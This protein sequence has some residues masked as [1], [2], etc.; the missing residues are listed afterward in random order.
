MDITIFPYSLVRYS[1]LE[2]NLLDDWQ[3]K[4]IDTR[5]AITILKEQICDKLFLL[6]NQQTDDKA[7]QKLIQLKRAI[8][9]DKPVN[10]TIPEELT[11]DM[12]LLMTARQVKK[13][14]ELHYDAQLVSHRKHLQ[15]LAGEE[16]LQKGILLSSP[17]LLEQMSHYTNKAPVDFK[18]KEYKIE[19]SLLRYITRMCFKTSP[20]ST[21]TYTGLMILGDHKTTPFREVKS[22]LKLNNSLFGYLMAII[23]QH[24][25]LNENLLLT[26]NSTTE[27][28]HAKLN[29]FVNYHNVEAFQQ[30]P[31]TTLNELILQQRNNIRLSELITAI[32][33][34]IEDVTYDDLKE[35][36]LKLAA[37]GLLEPGIGI[38][39]ME[40]DWSHQLMTY[41]SGQPADMI[42]QLHHWQESYANETAAGRF[43]ILKEAEVLV[44][45]VCSALQL[46]A[47]LPVATLENIP[48][49]KQLQTMQ[50]A[51]HHF[52]GRQIFYEDC[53][54]PQIEILAADPVRNIISKTDELL[55]YLSP[56]DTMKAEREKMRDFFINHYAQDERVKVITFYKDY[57]Y[58]VKKHETIENSTPAFNIQLPDLSSAINITADCF[59]HKGAV[60]SQSRG[61]FVQ[62]F[63][64]N[65]CGVINAILPGMGKVNG[66]FLSLFDKEV[67]D[68]FIEYNNR[69][70]PDI[71]KAE[72]NDASS[73]N[74]NIH[75]PLLSYE[76]TIP[77]GNNIYPANQ[78]I[79]VTALDVIYKSGTLHLYAGTKEIYTY[80]LSLESFNNRSNLYKLLAHFN[81]DVRPSLSTFLKIIDDRYELQYPQTDKDIYC[82]P[83]ISYEDVVVLRRKTWQIR[84]ITI[85]TPHKDESGLDYFIRLND[86]RSENELPEQAFLF[87]R[88]RSKRQDKKGGLDDDYKPQMIS[89]LQPLMIEL[90]KKLLSRA[91]E[92]VYLEEVLPEPS[93]TVKE[94]LLQWY[95]Y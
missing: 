10:T 43:R 6:V 57:Y 86:W 78:Q 47:G 42:R 81:P 40:E 76:I 20:F 21:F 28:V 88:K 68:C 95:K 44:N 30:I 51:H 5:S 53:Y 45:N 16:S 91:G 33:D 4:D 73:F 90:L 62:F 59:P 84:T 58:H 1:A 93:G 52:S 85:P 2:S 71:I 94:Y 31:N 54:T 56:L 87:L 35:Y 69:L 66:R 23:R 24:P 25:V 29:F 13:E 32:A 67:S 72:L 7:R 9:N 39:G 75:P 61:M 18:Q 19:F 22:R 63:N 37:T 12:A 64:N 3:L 34:E 27:T 74:A 77:G 46:E 83:R 38:S 70:Y 49:R 80:D 79:P 15:V 65:Q 11:A 60:V 41:L 92:Y 17:V 48:E 26:K 89:F 8:H 36:L 55:D 14:Q 50:F 82:W